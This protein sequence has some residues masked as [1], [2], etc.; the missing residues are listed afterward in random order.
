M[1]GESSGVHTRFIMGWK[2]EA[3]KMI[4]AN[5]NP[6]NMTNVTK[7]MSGNTHGMIITGH[8]MLLRYG[9]GQ[10]I[11]FRIKAS[12]CP[13]YENYRDANCCDFTTSVITW[14]EQVSCTATLLLDKT[15]QFTNSLGNKYALVK[16][17]VV[18]KNQVECYNGK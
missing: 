6:A 14:S 11:E 9:S 18:M 17:K 10:D 7:S 2:H 12:Y 1:Q 3:W 4:T 13:K 16:V 15:D 5:G 8:N